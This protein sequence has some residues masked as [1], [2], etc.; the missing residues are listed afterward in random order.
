MEGLFN[1]IQHPIPNAFGEKDVKINAPA[2]FREIYSVK[3]T[4][5]FRDPK[6]LNFDQP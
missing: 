2:L 4:R 1:T 3:Y 6:K 5:L